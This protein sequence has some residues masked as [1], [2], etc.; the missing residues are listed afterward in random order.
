MSEETKITNTTQPT[1]PTPEDKGGQGEKMFTQDEVNRIVSDR[2]ARERE[3]QTHQPQE[4]EREKALRE[5]ERALEAREARTA[6]QDYLDGL[7]D[8]QDKFKAALL[9]A[10]D[11]SDVDRFKA[12]AEKLVDTI[13][14]RTVTREVGAPP[15]ANPP[16]FYRSGEEAIARA[17]KP[18]I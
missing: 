15:P 11:T 13:G 17:F 4:D 1:T 10:L 3:K 5:R 12:T 8:V 6:C 16:T 7:S 9:G 2:L 14:L 18:K